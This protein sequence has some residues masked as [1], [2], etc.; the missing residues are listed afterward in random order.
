MQT[1][2]ILLQILL[3]MYWIVL[4]LSI[5]FKIYTPPRFGIAIAFIMTGI[6]MALLFFASVPITKVHIYHYR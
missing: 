4:G 2:E 1:V 6:L 3:I 5:L